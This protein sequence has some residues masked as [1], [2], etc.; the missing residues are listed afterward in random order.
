VNTSAEFVDTKRQQTEIFRF[1]PEGLHLLFEKEGEE[2]R[3]FP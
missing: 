2:D 3:K 1:F